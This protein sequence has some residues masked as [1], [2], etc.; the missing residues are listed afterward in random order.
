MGACK[1]DINWLA[2][3]HGFHDWVPKRHGF[4]MELYR[5]LEFS[6]STYLDPTQLGRPSEHNHWVISL[7]GAAKNTIGTVIIGDSHPKDIRV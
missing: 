4:S 2:L 7:G 5:Y 3:P 6:G 1:L